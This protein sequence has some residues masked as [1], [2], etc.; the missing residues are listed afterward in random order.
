MSK[1]IMILL[2]LVLALSF[3]QTAR[4]GTDDVMFNYQGRVLVDGTAYTGVGEM[5]VAIITTSGTAISLWSNDGSSVAAAEPA[6]SFPVQVIG[7]IFDIMVGD[8]AVGMDGLHGILFNRDD[9][10]AVRVWFNDGVNGFQQL[11]PDRRLT[12][13]RRL[14]INRI[15]E[16][17]TVYVSDTA[18]NDLNDGLTTDTAKKTIQ[19]AIDM[20]PKRIDATTTVDVADGTYAAF[21]VIG[22]GQGKGLLTIAG[23]PSVMPTMNANLPVIISSSKGPAITIASSGTGVH[24]DQSSKVKI[25]GLQANGFAIGFRAMN[26]SSLIEFEFCRANQCTLQGILTDFGSLA[27]VGS[28]LT[29]HCLEGI[30]VGRNSMITTGNSVTES[31]TVG[32]SASWHSSVWPSALII[33]NNTKGLYAHYGAQV[34]PSSQIAFTTNGTNTDIGQGSAL[35]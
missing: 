35:Y 6:L 31:N 28:S 14:G 18:G 1:R 22:F 9:E 4:A 11:V 13:P 25:I 19:A 34:V 8:E 12:N 7:G 20:L 17:L 23:G 27:S 15:A 5:K 2:G 21:A 10:L 16:P 26:A 24:V 30:T 29:D 33:R 32:L 3:Q